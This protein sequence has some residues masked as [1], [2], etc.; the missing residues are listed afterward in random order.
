LRIATARV[1]HRKA[2]DD[3]TVW[4]QRLEVVKFLEVTIALVRPRNGASDDEPQFFILV[5][6]VLSA[7]TV[8]AVGLV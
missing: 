7:S 5:I 1:H 8:I 6:L 4:R 3:E 2:A